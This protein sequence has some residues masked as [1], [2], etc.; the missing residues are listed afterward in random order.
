MRILQVY[1]DYY[2]PVKGGIES[3]INQLSK[4]LKD[5]RIDVQVLVSNTRNSIE[6]ETF[7]GIRITKAP[8]LGRFASA[9]L[10]PTF[11]CYLKRLGKTADIIHF[12]HPNPTAEF[13]YF[14]ASLKKKMVVT[15]HSD[16]I[17][18]DKLGKLYSPFRKRFLQMADKIIATSP[19]YIESSAVLSKFKNKCT[20]IPLGIDIKRFCSGNNLQKVEE[21]RSQNADKPIVLFVGCFRY[22]KGLHF[23]ISAMQ[24]IDAKLLLIGNGPE[25]SRLQNLAQRMHLNKKIE[26]L[27]E[28][29]DDDVNAYYKAC[30]IFVL[31]SHLRSEAFGLVQLEA[32][33]CKKPVIST[34]LGTGTSF[35]NVNKVTGLTVEPNNVNALSNSINYLIQNPEKRHFFGEM[36]YKRVNRLF[37]AD[38]MVDSIIKVYRDVL[39]DSR[40]IAPKPIYNT[41]LEESKHRKI[42]VLRVV[43]RLNIG[44]PTI[45]VK[46]LTEFLEPNKFL[47]KLVTGTISPNEG[48]MSY[49]T[50]FKGSTRITVPELQREIQL[51]KD[52]VALFKITK[53]VCQFEPDIIHSHTSK[54][55]S[56]SRIAAFICNLSRFKKII[57][58]HTF[59]GNVLHG[60][61]NPLKTY[62]I[63]MIEKILAIFTDR[64]I[65]ISKSQKWELSFVY[66]ICKPNKINTIKLGFNLDPFLNCDQKRGR[67]R[68]KLEISQD[69]ILIGIIGRMAPIKN[70]QM[71]LDSAKLL[72]ER[73]KI[74]NKIKFIL[75][76]DGEERPFL[77]AYVHSIGLDD[78]VIFHGWEKNISL[79][80]SDLDILAL[81]SV[82]EGTPVSVIEAMAAKVPVVTTGV[83]GIKDLL[84]KIE[85]RQPNQRNFKLCQRGILCP[86][87][88][89][90]TFFDALAFMIENGYLF[91]SKRFEEARN[92]V[93]NNYSVKRLIQ[94]VEAL[95]DKLISNQ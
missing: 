15:Y 25:F 71:F 36:G 39:K 49:I 8:Q 16:I 59:H 75:V 14:F 13:S 1:K 41:E 38:T 76:G 37:T 35:V 45:H 86:K 84:G 78:Y 17:R 4:G 34:D 73:T 62:V 24:K 23:L 74:K 47:T 52:F 95:Y 2:P 88:D 68:E 83:G 91:E 48:D 33:C 63:L 50:Q 44:G 51:L 69:T 67:L 43:S 30:D 65:A 31:P 55:G 87:N 18:Q 94:D 80:Y 92:Y 21:I 5:R 26:F 81:T 57:V 53:I 28:L 77:E 89:P 20:V 12:H 29:S 60:Y 85:S 66:K 90:D 46:N 7:G 72:T 9:P 19:D 82:N 70:H 93:V 42:K 3:H 32:M 61:F 10:T 56:L 11:K 64:I 79:I 54:A 22:Y 58:I 6:I 27:G 40:K